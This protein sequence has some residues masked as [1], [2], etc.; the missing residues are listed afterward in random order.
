MAKPVTRPNEMPSRKPKTRLFVEA[1]LAAGAGVD[2]TAPQ[3]HYLVNVLRLGIG[4]EVAVFNGLDGEWLARIERPGKGRHRLAVGKRTRRQD[5]EP[6]PWL[7]FAPIKRAPVDLLARKA[8]ELGVSRLWPVFTRNTAV[9]RINLRRLRANA[10]EAAEQCGRLTVPE[11]KEPLALERVFAGW[12][13]DRRL[14][15]L[16]ETG[17]GRPIAEALMAPDAGGTRG[18][19]AILA[20]PEGGFSRSEVDALA[21]LPFASAVG[22]GPRILRADTAA[23]AAL[24]CW[25]A[26]VGDWAEETTWA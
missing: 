12:P 15:V 18:A 7:L 8:T 11:V 14:L 5:A 2:L 24:A 6:G 10:V 9:S 3:A 20:G 17:G 4:D 21:E 1:A 22:L 16:D 13:E 23:L 19:S 25:Q 26:L